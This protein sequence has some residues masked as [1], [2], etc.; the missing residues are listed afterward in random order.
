[1]SKGKSI[2]RG[3]EKEKKGSL[4][5]G[6]Q[7]KEHTCVK[8]VILL[9]FRKIEMGC[10]GKDKENDMLC[11]ILSARNWMQCHI[12][13]QMVIQYPRKL[14]LRSWPQY[15]LIILQG[16]KQRLENEIEGH[17]K[18]TFILAIKFDCRKMKQDC[19]RVSNEKKLEKQIYKDR[20]V[21]SLTFLVSFNVIQQKKWRKLKPAIEKRTLWA[22]L[23]CLPWRTSIDA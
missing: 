10:W 14:F 15:L 2:E 9:S 23:K 8:S 20:C 16:S 4:T 7:M 3:W 17:Q 21:I 6:K 1:M 22:W 13:R 12:R 19:W 11:F 18:C 5:K